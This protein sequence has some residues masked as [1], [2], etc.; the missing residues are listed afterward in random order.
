[1]VMQAGVEKLARRSADK[2]SW[3]VLGY[4]LDALLVI[5]IALATWT[6][7]QLFAVE[8]RLVTLD[9]T[10]AAAAQAFQTLQSNQKEITKEL[11]QLKEWR[12]ETGANRFTAHDGREVWKEIANIRETIA[13]MALIEPP[14]WLI[15]RINMLEQRLQNLETRANK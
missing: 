1:M 5:L 13:R 11:A 10:Q 3:K 6:G 15:D 12:A 2:L 4:L 14:T 9:N 8:S 7:K